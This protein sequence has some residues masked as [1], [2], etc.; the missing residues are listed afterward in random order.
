MHIMTRTF[1]IYNFM[2]TTINQDR[3]IAELLIAVLV[4]IVF[5][6]GSKLN[7]KPHV[8]NFQKRFG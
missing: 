4:K 7:I 6:G 2:L 1:G 8:S 5:N 3:R